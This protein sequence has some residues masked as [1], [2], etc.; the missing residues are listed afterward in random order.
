MNIEL[1]GGLYSEEINAPEMPSDPTCCCVSMCADIGPKGSGGADVFRFTVVTPSFLALHP[2]TRWGT[3]Y[4]LVSEFSWP[5][6]ERM[7]HRLV[8]GTNAQTWAEAA[9]KLCRYM[10]WEFDN[11]QS[12]KGP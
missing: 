6:I 3:G 1:R 5:T 11:Y 9:Q 10:D 7:V 8:S 4:L 12:Y 2:E